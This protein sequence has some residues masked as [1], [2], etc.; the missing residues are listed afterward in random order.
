[1]VREMATILSLSGKKLKESIAENKAIC[2]EKFLPF[3]KHS[4]SNHQQT[5]SL[6]NSRL[7][8]KFYFAN[9]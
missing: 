7:S 6:K 1:V 8:K 3:N 4:P 2:R 5:N 9:Y